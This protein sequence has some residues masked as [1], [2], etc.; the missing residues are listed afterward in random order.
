[1]TLSHVLREQNKKADAL[2]KLGAASGVPTMSSRFLEKGSNN[3]EA[4]AKAVGNLGQGSNEGGADKSMGK[5]EKGG[6]DRA[7][8]KEMGRL[9]EN[10]RPEMILG[11]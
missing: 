8:A 9:G 4:E 3:K 10:G 2:V 5:R 1:M 6:N 11:I 7:G